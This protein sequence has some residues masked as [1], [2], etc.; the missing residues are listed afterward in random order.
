V[1]LGINREHCGKPD[2]AERPEE[3]RVQNIG[4][5]RH[6]INEDRHCGHEFWLAQSVEHVH[7]LGW[8]LYTKK[9]ALCQPLK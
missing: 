2:Q 5:K 8:Y 1:K 4:G 7:L 6:S 9:T 3:G